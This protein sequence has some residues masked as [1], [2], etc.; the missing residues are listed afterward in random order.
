MICSC[1]RAIH[2]NSRRMIMNLSRNWREHKFELGPEL[3]SAC[4]WGIGGD[5]LYS[6][7]VVTTNI[8]CNQ[9]SIPQVSK[10]HNSD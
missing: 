4:N 8:F 10:C 3:V 1:S 5:G 7:I 2:N 6:S 9:P